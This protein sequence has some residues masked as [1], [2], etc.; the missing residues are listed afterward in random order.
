MLVLS[1]NRDESIV[2]DARDF[3]AMA[4][5]AEAGEQI[6]IRVRVVDV[7]G[8]LVRLGIDAPRCIPVHRQEVF[9]KTELERGN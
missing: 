6:V 3:K 5:A 9:I 8:R 1:R 4:A 2:L 7:R